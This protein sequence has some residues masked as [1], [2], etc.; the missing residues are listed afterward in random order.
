MPPEIKYT[1]EIV[2][3]MSPQTVGCDGKCQK[4]WGIQM[5][6]QCRLSEDEDDY[7]YYKDSVLGRA[8]N[9]PG[10]SEGSHI[11]PYGDGHIKLNKWCVRQC[12]RSDMVEHGKELA[13]PDLENPTP[14]IPLE[15][16]LHRGHTNIHHRI[17]PIEI[18]LLLPP[19]PI[20]FIKDDN[21]GGRSCFSCGFSVPGGCRHSHKEWC[22]Q[23]GKNLHAKRGG[24]GR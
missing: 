1:K 4:A 23:V 16:R 15:N 18:E 3:A 12:E 11:K 2:F 21:D 24:H 13:I 22:D 19:H 7:V 9:D 5:R 14:N 20:E 17:V 8:P 10:T 6:P